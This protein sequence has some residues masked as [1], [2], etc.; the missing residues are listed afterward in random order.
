MK[1]GCRLELA[2]AARKLPLD[3]HQVVIPVHRHR[4][5]IADEE[6]AQPGLGAA[7]AESAE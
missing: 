7:L 2:Y 1:L 6:I 4:K 5:R 3:I